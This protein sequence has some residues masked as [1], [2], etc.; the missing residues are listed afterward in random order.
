MAPSHE[1]HPVSLSYSARINILLHQLHFMTLKLTLTAFALLMGIFTVYTSCARSL[2][3]QEPAIDLRWWTELSREW[4]NILLINQHFQTNGIDVFALHRQYINRMNS[5]GESE[6]SEMNTSLYEMNTLNRFSLG[7]ADLYAR[8]VQSG[9]I[10]QQNDID[11]DMLSQSDTLYMVNGPGDLSPLKKLPHL[12]VLILNDCGIGYNVPVKAQLLDLAPLATMKELKILHCSSSA[13]RSLEPIRKLIDLEELVIGNSSRLS[14]QP[15]LKITKLK[16][17]S[18]GSDVNHQ[19][20]IFGLRNLEE[21]SINSIRK[22]T[23]LKKLNKLKKL[24]LAEDELAIVDASYRITDICFLKT[25]TSLEFLDLRHTS[26]HGDLNEL[27]DLK[28]LKAITLPSVSRAHVALFRQ[29]KKD[30]IVI[31]SFE[32]E[33]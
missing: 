10:R 12:K 31:N 7:Y 27:T 8:A 30:C 13:L 3:Q 20:V 4:K 15:L 25:L 14:L 2:P 9:Q 18:V 21:L 23:Q 6:Y 19:R 29:L 1:E 11:L 16:K 22:T 33:Y 26:Y 32:F 5:A 24:S 28:N 17:L